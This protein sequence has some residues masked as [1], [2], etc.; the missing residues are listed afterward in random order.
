MPENPPSRTTMPGMIWRADKVLD[1]AL[2]PKTKGIRK[3]LFEKCKGIVL[4][5]SIEAGFTFTGKLGTGILMAKKL[6]GSWSVPSAIGL[7]AIGKSLEIVVIS[8]RTDNI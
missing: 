6:D 4:L 5:S 7:T 1:R 8:S 3:D 2:D